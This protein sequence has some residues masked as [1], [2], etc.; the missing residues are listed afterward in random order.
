MLIS[1]VHSRFI[2][3]KPCFVVLYCYPEPYCHLP[4]FV[5]LYCCET[6]CYPEPYCHLPLL[7]ILHRHC[8]FWER[9]RTVKATLSAQ[10]SSCVTL[11]I[12]TLLGKSYQN[13]GNGKLLLCCNRKFPS[14][15]CK[16]VVLY[17]YIQKSSLHCT[18]SHIMTCILYMR[19][20][21]YTTEYQ[22]NCVIAKTTKTCM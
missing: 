14:L 22:S 16:T 13:L 8:F 3:G 1:S 12:M 15:N 21:I 19:Y 6:R 20:T 11:R 5:V 2:Q 4:C 7:H 18:M 10:L 9:R 17:H